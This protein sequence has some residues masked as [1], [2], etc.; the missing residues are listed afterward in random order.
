MFPTQPHPRTSFGTVSMR[1]TGVRNVR[2]RQR[3]AYVNDRGGGDQV[4]VMCIYYNS[5]VS[6]VFL[7]YSIDSSFLTIA[8]FFDAKI[9]VYP[10]LDLSQSRPNV[11][12]ILIPTPHSFDNFFPFF[13][14]QSSLLR[15][16][17]SQ[18]DTYLS[19]H[20]G[21]VATD[22]EVRPLEQELVHLD[23]ALLES[24]LDVD[25]LALFAREGGDEFEGGAK[26]YG[27]FLWI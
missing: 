22:V 2:S 18:D 23:R 10:Q 16:N 13:E 14:T 27:V 1:P 19:R 6:F 17:L 12:L 8:F 3:A 24:I 21:R 25:F 9:T 4:W 26:G 20:I 11:L 7:S 15:H 5:V